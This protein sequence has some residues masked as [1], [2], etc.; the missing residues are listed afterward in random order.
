MHRMTTDFLRLEDA[1]LLGQCQVDTFR[2]HGPGGQKR[3]KTDSA[4]RLRHGPTG[5]TATAVE[6]RSQHANKAKALRRLRETIALHVR[7]PIDP[8][9]YSRGPG[10]VDCVTG[11]GVLHVGRRDRRYCAAVAEVLDVLAACRVQVSA[12]AETIG[13]STGQLVKWLERNPKL[14][15]RVNQMRQEAGLKR[16]R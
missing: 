2:S 6:E 1:E 7:S 13:V 16:L 14:W 3:N 8:D 10:L 4:V 11:D 12:A 5:L 15:E 9:H